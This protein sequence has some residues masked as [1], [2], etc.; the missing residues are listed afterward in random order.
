MHGGS[1]GSIEKCMTV[2]NDRDIATEDR[3]G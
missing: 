3:V 2:I 1:T